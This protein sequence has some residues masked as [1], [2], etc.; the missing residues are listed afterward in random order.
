MS[1]VI[2]WFEIPCADLDR[3]SA[4]YEGV[5]GVTLRREPMGAVEMAVFPYGDG[6]GGA[7]VQG[8]QFQPSA[9]GVLPYLGVS[10]VAAAL[11]RA[12]ER[13]AA[14]L[15]PLT[16][17]PD[18]IGDIAVFRDSEGNSIGIHAEAAAG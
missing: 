18:G 15:M 16:T 10:D 12:T 9:H 2:H 6:V 1:N 8:P 4:F 3:A 14:V 11:A 13:G 7:L 5:F 17:L